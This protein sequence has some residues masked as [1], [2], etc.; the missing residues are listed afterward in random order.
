MKKFWLILGLTLI[1]VAWG[2]IGGRGAGTSPAMAQY[3]APYTSP[4]YSPY[5]SCNPSDPYCYYDYYSA[6]Y[7]NPY[8]Q[9]FYYVVPKVGEELE[10]R[11]ERREYRERYYEGGRH[12]H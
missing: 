12:R 9:F 8:S 1:V 5:L 2:S 11:R 10:E 6:P 7:S 4:Y 3:Y